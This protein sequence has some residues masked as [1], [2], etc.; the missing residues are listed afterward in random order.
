MS[1]SKAIKETQGRQ[2]GKEL[3]SKGILV[4]SRGRKTLQEEVSEAYKDVAKVVDAC[5]RAGLSKKIAKLR[6]IGVIKG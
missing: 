6:P 4:Q 5:E 3:E 1:R 2:I